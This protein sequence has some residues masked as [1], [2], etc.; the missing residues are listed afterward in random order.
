MGSHLQLLHI[1]TSDFFYQ[2]F[3]L[4]R[5]LT[6]GY[7]QTMV[8][9]RRHLLPTQLRT[10]EG[11]KEYGP[12]TLSA[13]YIWVS[14]QIL[15]GQFS[16]VNMSIHRSK[17]KDRATWCTHAFKHKFQN[18]SDSTFISSCSHYPAENCL[19]FK[20]HFGLVFN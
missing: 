15:A 14:F 12:Q 3:S 6:C 7:K 8:T 20:L 2:M 10:W 19:D 5:T 11:E 18:I 17:S 9:R 1:P 4:P 13:K 16:V